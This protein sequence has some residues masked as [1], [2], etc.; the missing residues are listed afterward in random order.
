MAIT[1]VQEVWGVGRRIAKKLEEQGITI[2][3]QLAVS[4]LKWLSGS[5]NWQGNCLLIITT[6]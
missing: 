2:A 3:E 4:D 6:I 1:P 5:E